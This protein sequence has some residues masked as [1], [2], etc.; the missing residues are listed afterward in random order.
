MGKKRNGNNTKEK[1]KKIRNE[2][3]T[4]L[5]CILQRSSFVLFDESSII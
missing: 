2:S 1:K 5:S 3:T 4:N